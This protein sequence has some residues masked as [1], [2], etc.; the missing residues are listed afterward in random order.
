MPNTTASQ[1]EFQY[2]EPEGNSGRN[3]LLY[4]NPDYGGTSEG[5]IYLISNAVAMNASSAYEGD[6]GRNH[7]LYFN[8]EPE[9][10]FGGNQLLSIT[11]RRNERQFCLPDIPSLRGTSIGNQL[12]HQRPPQQADSSWPLQ[13]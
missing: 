10:Y 12:L 5:I 7:L 1:L 6:F 3:Q 9:G 2:S 8:P 4:I 13:F 11:G